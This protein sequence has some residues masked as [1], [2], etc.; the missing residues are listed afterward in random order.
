MTLIDPGD[1][2]GESDRV[3]EMDRID[4]WL[5]CQRRLAAYLTTF[6]RLDTL[7][8]CR[9]ENSYERDQAKT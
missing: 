3:R 6:I 7:A 8:Y 9:Y 4:T 5:S 1:R 2:P